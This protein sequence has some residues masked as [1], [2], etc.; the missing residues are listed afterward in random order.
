MATEIDGLIYWLWTP[1][2]I[3]ATSYW[4][5]YDHLDRPVRG[6]LDIMKCLIFLISVSSSTLGTWVILTIL[7]VRDPLLMII[8]VLSFVLYCMHL[9][10]ELAR[11]K[12]KADHYRDWREKKY[13]S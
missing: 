11:K 10:E 7:G 9:G 2:I 4:A 3:I 12:M 5:T 13:D 1:F 6:L 8:F